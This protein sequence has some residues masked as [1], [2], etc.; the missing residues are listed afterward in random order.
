MKKKINSSLEGNANDTISNLVD[1][2][3]KEINEQRKQRE[4][5]D[6][7]N[8]EMRRQKM[9]QTRIDKDGE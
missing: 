6:E 9:S 1:I 2:F 3:E 7:G 5:I 8:Y 4:R